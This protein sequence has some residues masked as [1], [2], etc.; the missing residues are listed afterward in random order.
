MK[1][2][3][4]LILTLGLSC[5]AAFAQKQ[6]KPLS[7]AYDVD[8]HMNFDNREFD[9]S[10]GKY[11]PSETLFGAR[12][13]PYVGLDYKK[14]S[15][16]HRMMLGLSLKKDFGSG[17]KNWNVFEKVLFYYTLK[18]HA[19]K[20]DFRMDAGIFPAYFCTGDYHPAIV[21]R[22]YKWQESYIEGVRFSLRNERGSHELL[23]HWL[24]MYDQNRREQFIIYGGGDV[25]IIPWLN[26]CYDFGLQHYAESVEAHGVVDNWMFNPYFQIDF[27]HWAP[28]MQRLHLNLGAFVAYERDRVNSSK[29][30]I[31]AGFDGLFEVRKWNVGIRNRFY[32]GDRLLTYY[33]CFDDAG[34]P[35]ADNLYH[36]EPF[37]QV[38]IEDNLLPACYDCLDVYYE[39]HICDFVDLRLDLSFHFN[40]GFSGWQQL[41]G[42]RFNLDRLMTSLQ[43]KKK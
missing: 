7:L 30:A 16:E 5:F 18:L 34:I 31:P 38:R 14:D 25:K 3:A 42:V 19:P 26:F 37:Y 24:G 36:G 41:V 22:K 33:S 21:S 43:S 11:A 10:Q 39:P 4:L 1:R 20:L 15:L 40:E 12:I 2:A 23:C 29:P 35:Y 6:E 9:Y 17:D 8:F 13:A 32:W 28:V 27:T